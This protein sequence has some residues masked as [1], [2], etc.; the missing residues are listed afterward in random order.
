MTLRYDPLGRLYEVA[1]AS[2]TRRFVWD[3]DAIVNQYNSAG[4]MTDRFVHGANAGADDPLVWYDSGGNINWLHA[5]H[6]G[7]ITG[8]TNGSTGARINAY[9]EWGIPVLDANGNNLN[10]G[11]FQ[12]TGQLWLPELGMYHYKARVYSPT[13]GRFLQTDPIGYADQFNLYAYVGDDPVNSVDPRGLWQCGGSASECKVI[14]QYVAQFHMAARRAQSLT[15]SRIPGAMARQVMA[16]SRHLGPEIDHYGPRIS[17]ANLDRGNPADTSSADGSIR[18]DLK[19]V[20]LGVRGGLV[21][22]A[23]VIG[24]EGHHSWVIS[25]RGAVGPMVRLGYTNERHTGC[26]QL[27]TK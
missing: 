13:L 23:G 24:H 15:G 16:V 8:V 25:Q 22:G 21:S 7:S 1:S 18:I 19:Q 12:Y 26:S 27:L 2:G 10:T 4:T 5:D 11:P 14:R 17:A 3:G 9:D 20:Y 6:Q